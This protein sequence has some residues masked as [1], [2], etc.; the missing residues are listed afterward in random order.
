MAQNTKYRVVGKKICLRLFSEEKKEYISKTFLKGE[1]FEASPLD[2]PKSFLDLVE[3]LGPAIPEE[4]EKE[5][6]PLEVFRPV[7]QKKE[8]E[9][10]VRK[11]K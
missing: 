7:R 3:N 8:K 5:E 10:F 1:E 11:K 9:E 4:V 2:V 6:S